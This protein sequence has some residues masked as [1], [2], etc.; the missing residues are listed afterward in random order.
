[1][2]PTSSAD[3]HVAVFDGT[4]GKLIKDSGFTIAKSVPADAVFT[5]TVYTHPVSGVTSGSYGAADNASPG[6]GGTFTVPYV[7][8]DVNGHTTAAANRTITFPAQPTSVT[9]NA[10]TATKLQNV[11]TIALTGDVTGSATFDGSA[12][13]SIAATVVNGGLNVQ[14]STTQPTDQKTGD[15]W[16]EPIS[17]I[18][19]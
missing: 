13:V 17:A 15:Q 5:D 7:T 1:M 4:T 12:D 9:G 2:G 10:G 16:F 3:A 6:F 8:V 14:Y 18:N 11:R 19:S